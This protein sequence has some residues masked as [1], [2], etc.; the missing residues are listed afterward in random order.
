MAIIVIKKPVREELEEEILQ[1]KYWRE[2]EREL[3]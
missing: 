1:V 2:G 3:K